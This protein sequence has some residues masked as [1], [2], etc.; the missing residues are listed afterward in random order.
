MQTYS[1][2]WYVC[3]LLKMMWLLY[4]Y[5]VQCFQKQKAQ[6]IFFNTNSS[7]TWISCFSHQPQIGNSALMKSPEKSTAFLL[8]K[9]Y[10]WPHKSTP[11]LSFWIVFMEYRQWI[12]FPSFSF[13]FSYRKI[14]QQEQDLPAPQNNST[15][16]RIPFIQ[17]I[18]SNLMFIAYNPLQCTL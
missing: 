9:K 14:L 11:Q 7:C 13:L 18:Y 2:R 6:V 10:E 16:L 3:M 1:K 5:L 15:V 17:D 8:R 4:V 12:V